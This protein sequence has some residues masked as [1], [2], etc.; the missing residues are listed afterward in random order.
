MLSLQNKLAYI[1]KA[2][3][4]ALPGLVFHYFRPESFPY[5]VWAEIAEGD[6]F[7]A[8]THKEEQVIQCTA[9]YYTKVEYDPNIDVIQEVLNSLEC[10]WRIESVQYEE[11]LK[12]IHYE[13]SFEVVEIGEV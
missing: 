3:N 6:S 12:L 11:V 10:P 9:D 7:H 1:G 8:D 4:D 13:W 2:F 5:L